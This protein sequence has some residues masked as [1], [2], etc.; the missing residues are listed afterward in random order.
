MIQW[1]QHLPLGWQ[2]AG[3]ISAYLAC[4]IIFTTF[5][6]LTPFAQE[7]FFRSPDDEVFGSALFTIFWPIGFLITVIF[8]GG[9]LL[10]CGSE[11][12]SRGGVSLQRWATRFKCLS[13]DRRVP[14]SA[15]Y[16]PWCSRKIGKN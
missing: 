13:C 1:L 3:G 9:W 10:G 2:I 8:G 12:L 7:E 11:F 5:A 14:W 15:T 6:R 4:G 16:C